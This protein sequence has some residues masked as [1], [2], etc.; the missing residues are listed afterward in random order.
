MGKLRSETPPMVKWIR[1][2]V[3]NESHYVV[4]R[5]G[6]KN[7]GNAPNTL[8]K[9]QIFFSLVNSEKVKKGKREFKNPFGRNDYAC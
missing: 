5:A 7:M 4:F 2:L 6:K 3:K 1:M 9:S 8:E